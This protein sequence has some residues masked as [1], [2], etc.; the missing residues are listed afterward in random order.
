MARMQKKSPARGDFLNWMNVLRNYSFT[1][2]AVI[3]LAFL[4]RRTPHI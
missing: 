1:I 4:V 2:S 3:F